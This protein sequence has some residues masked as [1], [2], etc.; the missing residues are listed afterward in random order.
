ME[1]SSQTLK[2]PITFHA[3]L[4][5]ETGEHHPIFSQLIDLYIKIFAEPPYNERFF[6]EN[7][8]KE[9]RHYVKNGT[10]F[11]A[12]VNEQ[13]VGLLGVTRGMEHC[14]EEIKKELNSFGI[15]TETDLYLADLAVSKEF[16]R[17]KIGSSLMDKMILKYPCRNMYLRTSAVKENIKVIA[18]YQK[19][20]FEVMEKREQVKNTRTDGS[21]YCDERLYMYKIREYLYDDDRFV[22]DGYKSG[23]EYLY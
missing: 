22:G 23:A 2:T 4:E 9:F 13:V 7:V 5:D 6:P 16:R 21:I 10:L 11:Y 19:L 17:K 20:G 14:Q 8:K 18:F 12:L 1:S 3:V 15:N